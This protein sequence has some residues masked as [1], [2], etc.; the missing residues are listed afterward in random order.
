MSSSDYIS[1]GYKDLSHMATDE[2]Y[3]SEAFM[4]KMTVHLS[5]IHI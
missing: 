4:D 5:L 2:F 3:I 1:D